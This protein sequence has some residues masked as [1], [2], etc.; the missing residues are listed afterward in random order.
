MIYQR[1]STTLAHLQTRSRTDYMDLPQEIIDEVID[2]LAFDFATLKF[3]S[4]V[5]KSWTHRSRRRLFYFVPINS[6]TRLEQWSLSISSDPEGIASYTRVVHLSHDTPRSW[7]EPANLD[8]FYDHFRSFPGVE[9]LV[10]SGLHTTK[11]GAT[12][13]PHYFANFTATVRSL[14]LRTAVGTADSFLSFICAFPLVDDLAIEFPNAIGGGWNNRGVMNL[15]SVPRFRGKLRLLDMFHESS[16]LVELLCAVPL[17]FHTIS[18]S[19]RNPGGLPQLA[20][21]VSKC[22][23]T[24]RSLHITSRARGTAFTHSSLLRRLRNSIQKIYWD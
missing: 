9:R 17:P 18:V 14:E 21:L 2:N 19:S 1:L 12:S 23:K 24:V 13:I 16:P 20:K 15:A 6:L 11:F 4:L 5:R 8:R 22:G 10:I 3:T 7:V